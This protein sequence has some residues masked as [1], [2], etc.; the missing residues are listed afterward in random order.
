MRIFLSLL[1]TNI[2][3]LCFGQANNVFRYYDENWNEINTPGLAF[4]YRTVEAI[5]DKY[6][7][8]DYYASTDEREMEA[9]CSKVSPE[10]IRD[11][12]SKWYYPNGVIKEDGYF[13][14]DKRIGLFKTN[15]E[16]G[17]SHSLILYGEDKTQYIQFWSD[18]G[19]PL[20]DKGTGFVDK[21][22]S[23]NENSSFMEIEDSL[24][25]AAYSIRPE[26]QDT[27]YLVTKSPAEFYGGMNSFY[28]GVGKALLGKYPKEARRKGIQG[29]V[30]IEFVIDKNG[31]MIEEKILKGIGGGCD[32]AALA[33]FSKLKKWKPASYKG[34]PVK[35]KMVL[36]V[37]FKLS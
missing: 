17:I 24:L 18:Q 9:V 34:R 10:L 1:F 12:E 11:G 21:V 28:E 3:F 32:E 5:A 30:F 20:L 13:K 23:I 31:A 25:V 4:Y 33:S 6:L 26:M 15:Y 2:Y 37:V 19:K 27:I 36:P 16:S 22:Y 29:R 14:N 8:T 7:V 35:T